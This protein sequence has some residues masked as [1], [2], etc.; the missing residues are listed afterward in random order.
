MGSVEMTANEL[1][2]AADEVRKQRV[3]QR[4]QKVLTV[5]VQPQTIEKARSLLGDGYTS[6]IRRLIV[7]A[8]NHP[9]MLKD[10]L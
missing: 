2:Q 8:L 6:V 10:C 4:K 7:K 5:R 9:E 3:A 1:R